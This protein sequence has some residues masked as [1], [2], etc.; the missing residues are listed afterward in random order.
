MFALRV[1]FPRLH[2]TVLSFA[3]L[4]DFHLHLNYLSCACQPCNCLLIFLVVRLVK[5]RCRRWQ[6]IKCRKCQKSLIIQ[7]AM[8]LIGASDSTNDQRK[9][10]FTAVA[11]EV[12]VV[13]CKENVV[14]IWGLPTVVVHFMSPYLCLVC[15]CSE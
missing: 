10:N 8:W 12:S 5:A 4:F 15:V 13:V 3:V 11:D 14:H 6:L 2:C 7:M 1:V 9:L